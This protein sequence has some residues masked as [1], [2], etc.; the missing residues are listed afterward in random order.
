MGLPDDG[1]PDRRRVAARGQDEHR[2]ARIAL[3]DL[4]GDLRL[5]AQPIAQRRSVKLA[6]PSAAHRVIG[7]EDRKP[8]GRNVVEHATLSVAV[9]LRRMM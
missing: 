8:G 5:L 7:I 2:F 3:D 6:Q 1:R 9:V 4:G